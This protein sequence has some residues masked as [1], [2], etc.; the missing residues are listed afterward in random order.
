MSVNNYDQL[1]VAI[2]SYLDGKIQL[3][4]LG[5]L[6]AEYDWELATAHSELSRAI[7]SIE[8][9]THEVGEGALSETDAR[10]QLVE[11]LHQ[12]ESPNQPASCT[13]VMARLPVGLICE[14]VSDDAIYFVDSRQFDYMVYRYDE[15]IANSCLMS[16]YDPFSVP[17]DN[18]PPE[19]PDTIATPHQI[20]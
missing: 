7:G 13:R 15:R 4:E 20:Q 3:T 8:L 1:L 11:L 12:L 18:F 6:V 16:G 2:Q 9:L 19:R 17:A 5:D 14:R 10:Q